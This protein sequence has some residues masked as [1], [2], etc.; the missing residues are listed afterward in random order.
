MAMPFEDSGHQIDGGH[1]VGGTGASHRRRSHLQ[2]KLIS[3]EAKYPSSST[4]HPSNDDE[5]LQHQKGNNDN[6]KGPQAPAAFRKYAGGLWSSVLPDFQWIPQ[7]ATWSKWKPVIRCAL[8]AW[9]CGLLFVIPKTE[10]AMGQVRYIL[11]DQQDHPTL[12]T[13]SVQA[14]FLILIGWHERLSCPSSALTRI[15]FER[16]FFHRPMILSWLSWSA[17][18]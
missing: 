6:Y 9:I 2:V 7:N 14:S 3:D 8:A 5:K 15:F 10:N 17:N 16:H 18:S 12:T 4:S 13:S 11:S 1:S